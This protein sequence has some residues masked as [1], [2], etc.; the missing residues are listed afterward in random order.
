MTQS[1]S[2]TPRFKTVYQS[3]DWP[4]YNNTLKNEGWVFVRNDGKDYNNIPYIRISK[5]VPSTVFPLVEPFKDY[6]EGLNEY[7]LRYVISPISDFDC[8][9]GP[10]Y[11][12]YCLVNLRSTPPPWPEHSEYPFLVT[13]YG[14]DDFAWHALYK[15][16]KEGDEVIDYLEQETD[17][18]TLYDFLK[19]YG[20]KSW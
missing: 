2:N 5:Q 3:V 10:F 11:D 8:L 17:M 9:C 13:C 16:R 4:T 1:N 6:I 15:T 12:Y 20:F 19:T 7:T 18:P 14:N